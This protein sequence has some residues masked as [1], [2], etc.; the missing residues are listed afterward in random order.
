MANRRAF[1]SAAALAWPLVAHRSAIAQAPAVATPPAPTDLPLF[2]VELRV[3]SR[4][5]PAKQPHEQ[6]YFREHSANLKRLRDDG[7]LVLGARYSD[8]GFL[9]LAAAS[10]AD[11]KTLLEADPSIQNEVFAF[12]IHPF[13]VFYSGCVSATGRRG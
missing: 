3:G 9:V 11:A 2:A 10:E 6:A 8:K 4:W 13:N 7:Q 5:E 12:Q 1:F